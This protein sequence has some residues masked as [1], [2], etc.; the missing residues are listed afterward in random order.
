MSSIS[1][2]VNR[3]WLLPARLRIALGRLLHL[4]LRCDQALSAFG[5][6]RAG[7]ALDEGCDAT[8]EDA[9]RWGSGERIPEQVK[10]RWTR[11]H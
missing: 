8:G 7:S 5:L 2:I 3:L 1:D 9:V 6:C 4:V 11:L 10:N